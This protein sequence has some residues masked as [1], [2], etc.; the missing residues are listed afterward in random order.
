M[1][2][3]SVVKSVVQSSTLHSPFSLYWISC[4]RLQHCIPPCLDLYRDSE[5]FFIVYSRRWYC[6]SRISLA[7]HH[8]PTLDAVMMC[9]RPTQSLHTNSSGPDSCINAVRYALC[10]P[11]REELRVIQQAEIPPDRPRFVGH[12]F[13]EGRHGPGLSAA[14]KG[15]SRHFSSPPL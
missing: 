3:A 4:N 14:I 5:R 12:Q 2:I 1:T 10:P 6:T 13:Q 15:H 11:I 9:P 8:S 7:T